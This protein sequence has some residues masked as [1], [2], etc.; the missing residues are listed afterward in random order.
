M[1]VT[2]PVVTGMALNDALAGITAAGL[3]P[4]TTEEASDTVPAG[5]VVSQNPAGGATVSPDSTVSIVVS[6]G[7]ANDGC[8]CTKSDS[9][10]TPGDLRKRLGELFLGGLSLMFLLACAKHRT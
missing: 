4:Q 2:V 8:R 9:N 10:F 1:T 7:P 3:V 6:T 5:Q